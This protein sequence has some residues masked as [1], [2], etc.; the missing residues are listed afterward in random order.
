MCNRLF[1][2]AL[3]GLGVKRENISYRSFTEQATT[4]ER[5]AR[6]HREEAGQI[7]KLIGEIYA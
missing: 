4:Y 3:K 1:L 5:L 2:S 7:E 6:E